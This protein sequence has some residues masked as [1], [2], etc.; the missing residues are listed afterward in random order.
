MADWPKI[1]RIA[2]SIDTV[3]RLI[4]ILILSSFCH[5]PE[6]ASIARVWNEQNLAAIRLDFPNPA[7]QARNLFH[8]SVAMWDT[9]AAFDTNALGY[10]HNETATATD[11]AAARREAISY[12]AYRVLAHRYALS[13][14]VSNTLPALAAQMTSLGFDPANTRTT[15]STP[16]ALGNRVAATV[17]GFAASDRSNELTLYSDPTYSPVNDPLIL[18]LA[19]T[20]LNDLNRWQ[21]LAFD[22]A[23]T[24]NGLVA[25][26]IQI[27][28]GS[29]WGAV[30][31]FTLELQPNESVYLDPGT[32]PQLGGVGDADYRAGVVSVIEYSNLMDPAD[33]NTIDISPASL[34]NNTLGQN[35]GTGYPINP[36]TGL[37]YAQQIVP[38]GDYGRV[39]AE[40]WAD[41]PES[42]TPP[43]HWNKLANE[44][45]DH[46]SLQR[47]IGGTGPLVDELEWDVKMYF[48][49][50][51]AVHDAAV[52]AW[53]CKR[54]Y[55]YIRPI[56]SIRYMAGVGQSTDSTAPGFHPNGLPLIPGLIERITS[57][58]AAVG[59]RHF[60]LVPGSMAIFAWGGEPANPETEFTGTKWI[61]ANTWLPY[62]RDT[63]VTPAFAGYVSGHSAFSRAAAEVLTRMTGTSSF[64]GGMGTF[65]APRNQYL[66]FEEGPSVDITLQWATYYDAADEAGKSRLYG[67]IHV[68]VDDGPGRIM[69]SQCGI[70][71]W[72]RASKYF[73][74]SIINNPVNVDFQV[75][76]FNNCTFGWNSLPGFSYTVEFSLNLQNFTPLIGSQQ[77]NESTDHFSVSIPGAEKF[78]FRVKKSAGG[79]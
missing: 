16:A 6:A 63:F 39:I 70:Q 8:T 41:G 10:V 71:V 42:E 55:D 26:Q 68:P 28:I 54:H 79:N 36:A 1:T 17:L 35:D 76:A 69:G 64:P 46:P 12:A 66:E 57:E 78:F 60:G 59:Q 50:N 24:Q 2:S 58:S 52:A 33:G 4:T 14:S 61:H 65:H 32:P 19:G 45:S 73:D 74:G 44:V 48:A 40:F 31:P 49:L 5:Q 30:R 20:T 43:G 11:V 72:E 34:G 62:Q 15:D 25:S 53:T 22:I 23:F 51:A 47:R 56:S 3:K 18:A 7:V 75:G 77:S 37:P 67:G 13:V 38:H 21:P 27:Y 9:W 29:H